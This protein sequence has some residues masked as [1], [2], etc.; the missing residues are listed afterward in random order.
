LNVAY[1]FLGGNKKVAFRIKGRVDKGKLGF[2]LL[3][4]SHYRIRELDS[5][6]KFVKEQIKKTFINEQSF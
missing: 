5:F 2:P 4:H 3:L 1:N 6:L